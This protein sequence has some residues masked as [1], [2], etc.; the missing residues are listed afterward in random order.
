M[1]RCS[2]CGATMSQPLDRCPK[3]GVLLSGVKCEACGY[4]GGKTE[5]INNNHRCP[6]CNSITY[7]PGAPR[8]STSRPSAPNKRLTGYSGSRERPGCVTAYV[9]LLWIAAVL[10]ALGGIVTGINEK[11]FGIVIGGVVVGGLEFVLATGIWRLK[12][13]ARIIVIVL[14]SVGVVVGVISLFMGNLAS[15][16]GLAIGGYILYW[17]ASHREYFG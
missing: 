12:N 10:I 6:K 17:F 7:I 11:Q 8:P 13:W 16:I 1:Y 3:C 14:Q 2:N 4:I 15:I 9:I 5:F